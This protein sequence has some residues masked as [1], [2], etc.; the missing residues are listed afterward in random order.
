MGPDAPA[1]SDDRLDMIEKAG[2]FGI[3]PGLFVKLP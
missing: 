3:E 1:L 2:D